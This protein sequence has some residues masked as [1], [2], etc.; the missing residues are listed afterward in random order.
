MLQEQRDALREVETAYLAC[1]SRAEE[2]ELRRPL[3]RLVAEKHS[4][5]AC[6]ALAKVRA[7]ARVLLRRRLWMVGIE[8]GPRAA[9]PCRVC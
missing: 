4:G 6:L 7:A 2:A 3:E 1:A 9:G 8:R 5:A